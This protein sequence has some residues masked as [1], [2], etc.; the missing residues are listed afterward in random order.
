M[1]GQPPPPPPPPLPLPDEGMA[2]QLQL[3][4]TPPPPGFYGASRDEIAKGINL[5]LDITTPYLR[6]LGAAAAAK[7]AGAP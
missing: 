6:R 7:V 2:F 3:P 1:Q 5:G 4:T